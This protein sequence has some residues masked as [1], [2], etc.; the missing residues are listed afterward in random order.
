MRRPRAVK[1]SKETQMLA[2]YIAI[3]VRNAMEDFHYKHLT[4]VQ[5]KELNPIIR[6]AICSALHAYVNCEKYKNA[7]TFFNFSL[8]CIPDYWEEPEIDDFL[9]E[10]GESE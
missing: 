6:N 1:P 9:K 10:T 8:R 2:K 3:V 5:M 7:E 4:D